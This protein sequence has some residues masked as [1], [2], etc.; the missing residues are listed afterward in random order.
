MAAEWMGWVEDDFEAD[1]GAGWF[2]AGVKDGTD[3]PRT[4]GLEAEEDI[5]AVEGDDDGL[6]LVGVA[7]STVAGFAEPT[8]IAEPLKNRHGSSLSLVGQSHLESAEHG[9][10]GHSRIAVDGSGGGGDDERGG[11]GWNSKAAG[12]VAGMGDPCTAEG[13]EHAEVEDWDSAKAAEGHRW[14]AEDGLVGRILGAAVRTLGEADR[15]LEE[16]DHMGLEVEQHR[17]R[18]LEGEE[19]DMASDSQMQRGD[20]EDGRSGW[21]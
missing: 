19:E 14:D 2:A 8:H 21:R 16:V 11:D 17:R 6:S 10:G 1:D 12:E 15:S 13:A 18:D 3:T 5:G 7:A 20:G 9:D 4:G